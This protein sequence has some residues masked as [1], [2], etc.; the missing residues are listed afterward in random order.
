[1]RSSETGLVWEL[2]NI[3]GDLT[4]VERSEVVQGGCSLQVIFMDL[5]TWIYRESS[6][7]KNGPW[8]YSAAG[9]FADD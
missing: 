9:I 3:Q 1:M 4:M 7:R 2:L 8:K 6:F 5:A